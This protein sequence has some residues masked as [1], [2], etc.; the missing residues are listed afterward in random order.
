[1]KLVYAACQA[2]IY[3]VSFPYKT[4]MIFRPKQLNIGR[5]VSKN[6]ENIAKVSVESDT[7]KIGMTF[8]TKAKKWNAE[9]STADGWKN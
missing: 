5:L 9:I 1:M 4:V 2:S 3:D 7:A 6:G 8:S